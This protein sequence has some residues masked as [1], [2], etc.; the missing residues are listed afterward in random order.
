METVPLRPVNAGQLAAL[1]G[2]I[3]TL[4]PIIISGI[5]VLAIFMS[6]SDKMTALEWTTL[7]KISH[8]SYMYTL[9]LYIVCGTVYETLT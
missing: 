9:L 3:N 2:I 1:I 6:T 8:V 4:L 5:G 7:N